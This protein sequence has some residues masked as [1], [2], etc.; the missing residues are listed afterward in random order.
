MCACVKDPYRG[1]GAVMKTQ[2]TSVEW[3]GKLERVLIGMAKQ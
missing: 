2:G 3:F 1:G